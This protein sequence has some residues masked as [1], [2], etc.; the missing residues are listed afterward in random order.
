[1]T[2]D[3]IG[4]AADLEV[5]CEVDGVVMQHGRTSDLLFGPAAV[6]SYISQFAT[7]CQATDLDGNPGGVG[8]GATASVPRGRS[9]LTTAIE[10]SAAA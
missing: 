8:A 3:E 9:M 7:L 4:D 10:G 6:V 1:V 5:R 2:G